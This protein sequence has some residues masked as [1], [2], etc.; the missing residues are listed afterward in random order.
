MRDF[1][2]LPKFMTPATTVLA[3]ARAR[4]NIQ[5]GKVAAY[6]LKSPGQLSAWADRAGR[7]LAVS[8]IA[9]TRVAGGMATP[10]T[11]SSPD[12]AVI[13]RSYAAATGSASARGFLQAL[14]TS[15]YKTFH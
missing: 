6:A 14:S 3:T 9:A 2:I 1:Y 4:A 10:Q 15:H 11:T 7:L 13:R 5:A 12:R 8:V